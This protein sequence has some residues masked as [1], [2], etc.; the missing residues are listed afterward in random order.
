MTKVM[1]TTAC[2][3]SAGVGL[4]AESIPLQQQA[5]PQVFNAVDVLVIGSSSRKDVKDAAAAKRGMSVD[6]IS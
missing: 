3:L 5:V 2:C 1:C 4:A 6:L